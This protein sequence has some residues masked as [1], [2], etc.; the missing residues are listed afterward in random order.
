MC[1]SKNEKD[2]SRAGS[3]C[4][5]DRHSAW[6]P[7]LVATAPSEVSGNACC[8]CRCDCVPLHIS[9]PGR[10][11]SKECARRSPASRSVGMCKIRRSLPRPCVSVG[12]YSR[13]R[14]TAKVN[15][16]PYRCENHALA[17]V[18]IARAQCDSRAVRLCQNDGG[19]EG[20]RSS[21]GVHVA[22]LR[23]PHV[24]TRRFQRQECRR[25]GLVSES[26]HRRVN[27]RMQVA[28]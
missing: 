11:L 18:G 28:P 12:S 3:K 19:V 2:R 26:V 4:M 17:E 8:L 24:F 6:P 9:I 10:D 14:C 27:R 20:R 1:A 7:I 13:R 25:P 21:T 16:L 15:R 22:R 23:R 5:R